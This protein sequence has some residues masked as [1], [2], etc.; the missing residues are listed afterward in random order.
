MRSSRMAGSSSRKSGMGQNSSQGGGGHAIIVRDP[1][2]Q[3]DVT[4]ISLLDTVGLARPFNTH[5]HSHSH[6]HILNTH[7]AC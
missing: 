2:T 5:S 4:P 3:L 7:V 1:E 6:S